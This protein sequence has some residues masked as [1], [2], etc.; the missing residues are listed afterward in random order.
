MVC[1]DREMLVFSIVFGNPSFD[2]CG[3]WW[4]SEK[5][6][7]IDVCPLESLSSSG[8]DLRTECGDKLGCHRWMKTNN[9]TNWEETSNRWARTWGTGTA[10]WIQ[11]LV[12]THLQSESVWWR[13]RSLRP[14]SAWGAGLGVWLSQLNTRSLQEIYIS[15][16]FFFLISSLPVECVTLEAGV[17]EAA[18][19]SGWG[20]VAPAQNLGRLVTPDGEQTTDLLILWRLDTDQWEVEILVTLGLVTLVLRAQ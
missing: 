11:I 15:I 5:P 2:I 6:V 20:W 1:A 12:V 13:P 10:H 7:T 14:P 16:D 18:E 19:A 8:Q 3:N 9:W 17:R 4:V